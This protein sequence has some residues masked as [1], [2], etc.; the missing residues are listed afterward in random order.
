M[1]AELQ[2]LSR[3]PDAREE[4]VRRRR[5][6]PGD[7]ARGPELGPLAEVEAPWCARRSALLLAGGQRSDRSLGASPPAGAP[8]G[9]PSSPGAQKNILSLVQSAPCRL[10]IE[11]KD[12]AGKAYKRTAT[13][14][15]KT[16]ETEEMPLYSNKETICGEVQ[17]RMA[18][19]GG[20]GAPTKGSCATGVAAA[21]VWL[22][23]GCTTQGCRGSGQ[24]AGGRAPNSFRASSH[25]VTRSA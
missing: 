23:G 7:R 1:R 14:K 25:C 9:P 15:G 10:D 11:F 13:V 5:G 22:A 2:Q 21:G 8:A 17:G 24:V 20:A 4:A 19:E 3:K 12:E 6:A 18:G 16:G